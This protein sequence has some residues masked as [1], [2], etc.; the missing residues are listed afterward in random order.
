MFQHSAQYWRPPSRRTGLCFLLQLTSFVLVNRSQLGSSD[1]QSGQSFFA[2]F[3]LEP[4]CG[5]PIDLVFALAPTIPAGL[6]NAD[7]GLQ[8]ESFHNLEIIELSGL[9]SPPPPPPSMRKDS[10]A[11]VYCFRLFFR[12]I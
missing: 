10:F 1:D 2:I 8:A 3:S 11:S 9:Y 7:D 12:R 5:L 4:L 6:K